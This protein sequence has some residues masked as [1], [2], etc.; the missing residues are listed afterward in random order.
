MF[1]NF[2]RFFCLIRFDSLLKIMS[3]RLCLFYV[4]RV[5]TLRFRVG[6]RRV[7]T[8]K[9]Y[10]SASGDIKRVEPLSEKLWVGFVIFVSVRL[11]KSLRFS[12]ICR[13]RYK[14]MKHLVCGWIGVIFLLLLSVACSR[15]EA[16]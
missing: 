3:L 5:R 6:K 13:N 16:D 14:I 7:L 4:F 2:R 9:T 10:G 1:L 15:Q 8:R 12:Y 11:Y